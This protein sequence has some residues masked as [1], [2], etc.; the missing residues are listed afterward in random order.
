MTN[1]DVRNKEKFY[2]GNNNPE[3]RKKGLYKNFITGV[4]DI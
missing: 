4:L 2:N 1:L 3:K